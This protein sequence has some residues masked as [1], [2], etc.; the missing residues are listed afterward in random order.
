[1]RRGT[2]HQNQ[3]Q[4]VFSDFSGGLNTSISCDRIAENQLSNATNVEV[5]HTTGALKTVAGT[6]NWRNFQ[7]IFA[8]LYDDINKK[9]LV[10]KS[11]RKVYAVDLDT[12]KV[13]SELGTLNGELYPISASWEDGLLIA[14]G[15]K[16]QYFNGKRLSTIETSPTATSV[17]VRAGRILVTDATSIR[18]SGIGDEETW[19]LETNVASSGTF[20]EAGYKDGG[21]LIGIVN[22][23]SD[24]L[25]IKDN[26]RVYRLSGEYPEWSMTE[27]SRNVEVTGRLG[28]CAVADS[29]FVLG[30]NAVQNI[31]TTNDYGDM[32][33]QDVAVLVTKEIQT[34]SENAFLRYVPP[35]KQIWAISGAS[36]MIFDLVTQ[37]WYK[38]QF[39]SAVV[40]VIPV[41]DEVFVIKPD[42]IAK[43]SEMSFY[44]SNAPL[45]WRWQARRLISHHNYF[46]KRTSVSISPIDVQVYTGRVRAGA[47]VVDIPALPRKLTNERRNFVFSKG[48]P[49]YNNHA[50]IYGNM[51]MIYNRPTIVAENRNVYRSKFLDIGGNG[52]AGGLMF[53]S[54]T[55]DL[56]EV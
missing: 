23:S 22:L 33:P 6:V 44:D 25:L 13:S 28:I 18:Y 35:L 4:I 41:G 16:L 47:V 20:V 26:R 5:D 43:L 45:T 50:L 3:F 14:S 1:M 56:V 19:V 24:V 42:H 2:K 48:E 30:R 9:F 37:S 46:L 32:K 21:K 7:N 15:S 53:N 52:S 54:V 36:A 40:D 8:T 34:L 55:L 51:A 31:L 29:V 11:N 38:R 27:V 17:Y 39:N 49:I 12:G 10:V